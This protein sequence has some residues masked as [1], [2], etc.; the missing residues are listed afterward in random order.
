MENICCGLCPANSWSC[1]QPG[2]HCPES[3][4]PLGFLVP[5]HL[6][7]GEMWSSLFVLMQTV[8]YSVR[9]QSTLQSCHVSKPEE[10]ANFSHSVIEDFHDSRAENLCIV[11]VYASRLWTSFGL[12]FVWT[13]SRIQLDLYLNGRAAP[14]NV[15]LGIGGLR[16]RLFL[17]DSLAF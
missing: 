14:L 2:L 6:F 8:S 13:S 17:N 10:K 1:Q 15:T 3:S 12:W 9:K 7:L 5:T 11:S 16:S 4:L